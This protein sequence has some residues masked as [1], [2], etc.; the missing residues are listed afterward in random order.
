MELKRY[1]TARAVLYVCPIPE[2]DASKRERERLTEAA[3]L[4]HIFGQPVT[5]AHDADGK[6]SLDGRPEHISI[7]HS[8]G[9]LCIALSAEEVGVDI[10]DI[11]P[12]L[13]RVKERFLT[14]D[15]QQQWLQLHADGNLTPLQRL[16]VCWSAK[17]ALYKLAGSRAGALGENILISVGEI[18]KNN[19][20]HAAIGR[21]RFTLQT[22]EMN[23]QYE[24]TLAWRC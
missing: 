17:E 24:I 10:E 21:E 16:A 4:Q 6:P 15:E 7:S 8:R 23:P 22:V 2:A 13:E 3:L 11:S 1:D 12:R 9:R 18:G 20:F 14:A 19:I 5:L